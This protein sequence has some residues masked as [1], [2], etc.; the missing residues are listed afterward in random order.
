VFTFPCGGTCAETRA[1]IDSIAARIGVSAC[2][3][4]RGHYVAARY[5]GPVEYRAVAICKQDHHG[6]PGAAR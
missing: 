5:F 6:K 4:G 1:E 2:D 3:N